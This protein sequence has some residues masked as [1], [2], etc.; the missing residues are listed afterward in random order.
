MNFAEFEKSTDRT[1]N[2]HPGSSN[3]GLLNAG[4][5]TA[6][7]GGEVADLVKKEVFHKKIIPVSRYLEEVGDVLYYLARIAR[8]K[9]FSLEEAALRNKLKLL[10][11][12]PYG[13]IAAESSATD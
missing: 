5:G 4:L 10:V 8:E 2:R 3:W 6:S 12:Y 13:F 1:W 7:E 11:R 9:G